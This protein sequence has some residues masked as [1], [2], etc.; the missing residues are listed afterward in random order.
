MKMASQDK[1]RKD[2]D[3]NIVQFHKRL[4]EKDA[5]TIQQ[6]KEDN[7]RI[8]KQFDAN[9][10]QKQYHIDKLEEYMKSIPLM[11]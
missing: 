1:I 11:K 4:H 10:V 3:V 6:L 7:K 2:F 5:I 8:L 9:K